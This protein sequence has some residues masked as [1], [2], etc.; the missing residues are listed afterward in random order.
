MT[1]D[2]CKMTTNGR[3]EFHWSPLDQSGNTWG[4][5][6]SSPGVAVMVVAFF[7]MKVNV[8]SSFL[9]TVRC[10]AVYD[11]HHLRS[12]MSSAGVEFKAHWS[13]VGQ[14]FLSLFFLM[15]FL[16]VGKWM[17]ARLDHHSFLL[18][19][20]L[21]FSDFQT[22]WF[23]WCRPFHVFRTFISMVSNAGINM[24][25]TTVSHPFFALLRLGRTTCTCAVSSL[26]CS[27][28]FGSFFQISISQYISLILSLLP[29]THR[30]HFSSP[31]LVCMCPYSCRNTRCQP[32]IRRPDPGIFDTC[33]HCLINS[34]QFLITDF[35]HIL[36]FSLF[37]N[38]E[39]RDTIQRRGIGASRRRPFQPFF[40]GLWFRLLV[41]FNSLC[42]IGIV[43]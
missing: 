32:S 19:N 3:V 23:A 41:K 21:S 22:S 39:I 11:V 8:W 24:L 40:G 43:G 31:S 6:K 25:Y 13:S 42:A 16:C 37:L 30:P 18:C 33:A 10:D 17:Y 26:I 35:A 20:W 9:S 34:F 4:R 14:S 7:P 36:S 29:L 28:Q 5:V 38:S 12:V 1:L 27:S 15:R 2:W